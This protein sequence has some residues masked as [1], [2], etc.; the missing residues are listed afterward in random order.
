MISLWK[1]ISKNTDNQPLDILLKKE[2]MVEKK[3]HF[4]I[5]ENYYFICGNFYFFIKGVLHFRFLK[6]ENI[7]YFCSTY[8]LKYQF[9]YFISFYS[10]V[11][12][13]ILVCFQSQ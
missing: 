11:T 5:I 12:L 3:I 13:I 1:P 9:N 4:K 2:K 10:V 7:L 6:Y 8:A